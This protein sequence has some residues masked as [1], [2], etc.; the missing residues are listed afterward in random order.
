MLHLRR[1]SS[2]WFEK[3]KK[4]KDRLVAKIEGGKAKKPE[5]RHREGEGTSRE[6]TRKGNCSVSRTRRED[7]LFS[8]TISKRGVGNSGLPFFQQN[9]RGKDAIFRRPPRNSRSEEN[10]GRMVCTAGGIFLAFQ[11]KSGRRDWR[12]VSSLQPQR[13]EK[14]REKEK[15][16][17]GTCPKKRRLLRNSYGFLRKGGSSSRKKWRPRSRKE[18]LTPAHAR[19][20][21][22]QQKEIPRERKSTCR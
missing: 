2:E 1:G 6:G 11:R 10:R 14:T 17:G 19:P 21:P 16:G 4:K 8:G 5:R 22:S 3:K 15:G 7:T 18:T 20:P 12:S 13:E 9:R